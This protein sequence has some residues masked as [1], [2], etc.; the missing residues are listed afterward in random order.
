MYMY[1]YSERDR[2]RWRE[3]SGKVR[4][5]CLE[6]RESARGTCTNQQDRDPPHNPGCRPTII[7]THVYPPVYCSVVQ[8]G[9]VCCSALQCVAVRCSALQCV[10]MCGSALQCVFVCCSVLLRA[11][12]RCG[13]LQCMTV[14]VVCPMEDICERHASFTCDMMHSYT[15]WRIIHM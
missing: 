7:T 15:T 12:V 1:R 8:C 14:C 3:E 11:A 6:E 10:A 5:Q 13:V 4:C 9:P 2:E